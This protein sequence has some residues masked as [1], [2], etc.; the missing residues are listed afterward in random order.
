VLLNIQWQSSGKR[1]TSS[2]P[3]GQKLAPSKLA[4]F[5]AQAMVDRAPKTHLQGL[6]QDREQSDEMD[7]SAKRNSATRAQCPNPAECNMQ[8]TGLPTSTH[9]AT[10]MQIV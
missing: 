3:G 10:L 5:S 6:F 7:Q 2:Q 1:S 4:Q 9:A 8:E